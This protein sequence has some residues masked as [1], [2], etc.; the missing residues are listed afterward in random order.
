VRRPLALALGGTGLLVLFVLRAVLDPSTDRLPGIDSGNIYTWEVYTRSALSDARLP[1]WNPYHFAGTPH[2]ADPQTTVFY[3]PALALRW[4]PVPAFLGWMMALHL[5]IAGAGTLFAARVLGL[6]WGAAS[7]AAVALMLGGS[8]PGWIH[9]GHLLLL[10]SAAW[11]PWA[12]ALAFQSVRSR[13]VVPDGRL[14]AVLVLQFL[15]GYLQGSLYLAAALGLYFL[16]SA[17]WPD[18]SVPPVPRWI[19]VAQLVVLA[20]LSVAAAAFQL[21]PTA[22]LVVQAGRSSGIPY[23]DAVEGSWRVGDLTTLFF[24]FYGVTDMPPYRSLSDRLAYV[25]WILTAFAPF[26]FFIRDRRR[27]AV[28]LGLLAALVCALALGDSTPLF[29]LQYA[30]FPGLRVPGRVL[31]LMTFAL[32]LLGAL[33]LEAFVSLAVSRQYRRL[34]IPLALSVAALVAAGSRAFG[35]P[36]VAAPGWPWLP[37]TLAVCVLAV[38]AAGILGSPRLALV[39]AVT[40]VVLDLTSLSLGAVATIPLEEAA[41][42]RRSIGSPDGGRAISLCEN[43]IGAREFLLNGQPT[44]DGLPGLHLRDYAE[45]AYL[46]KAGDIPPGDGLFRRLGSEGQPPV[47]TDLLD[48]ANVTRMVSCPPQSADTSRQLSATG[49]AYTVGRNEGAW[50]RAVWMCAVDEVTRPE[51]IARLLQDRYDS[52]GTL[53]PRHF[54]KV[55]WAPGVDDARRRD[56]ERIHRL[57]EGVVD[58]GVTWRYRLGDPSTDAVLSIL[59]DPG[60]EDT[61]GVDRRSGAIMPTDELKR[62]IPVVT[63]AESTERQLL[64]G[65]MPCASPAEVAVVT[66]DQPDGHVSARVNAPAAGHLFFSEPYYAERHAFIDGKRVPAMRAD[67]AFTAV[68]VPAGS[69]Q[70]ELRYVPTSFYAGS[71]I[72]GATGA[73]YA[74]LALWRRKRRLR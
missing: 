63:G 24:P 22:T 69:H 26:A 34:A 16:F 44:L 39:T 9:N 68:A 29:R 2:L 45:W 3:P 47:R 19:P 13:R 36:S 15:T 37:S 71:L 56:L 33:G 51:A 48:T 66:A 10:Y 73:C 50:P 53:H 67:V 27:I 8:V 18:R 12:F 25:G 38:L 54:I 5:W 31:F 42:I 70:V 21:V 60:V 46:A 74:G 43:R 30:I 55:R 23:A 17:V 62:A 28:F 6:G 1:F 14:V 35:S 52:K 65:T 7:A 61:H 41:A 59:R 20:V 11:V 64:V 49:S 32:A 40:V 58:E 57:E 72:S 4:L